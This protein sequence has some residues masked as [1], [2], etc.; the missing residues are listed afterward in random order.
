M[1]GQA[2]REVFS[3]PFFVIL[4][5]TS[6]L[7]V[8]TALGYLVS[9]YVLVPDPARRQPGGGSRA[10]ADWLDRH[11][12]LT[13]GIEIGVMLLAAI[14]AMATDPWFSPR[15]KSKSKKREGKA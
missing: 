12:P 3:N 6:T 2:R 15:S 14:L 10:L 9:P 11:G 8:L 13:L 5:G 1:T 4:L 7:F